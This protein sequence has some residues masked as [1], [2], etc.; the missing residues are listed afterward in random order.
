M[1]LKLILCIQAFQ[2][3]K[4]LLWRR[5][6]QSDDIHH[7]LVEGHAYT[8][9]IGAL[10]AQTHAPATNISLDTRILMALIAKMQILHQPQS[11]GSGHRS[12][13]QTPERFHSLKQ[14]PQSFRL[15]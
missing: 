8:K 14:P 7:R 5:I 6:R 13:G 11:P 4:C 9:Q 1:I 2:K 10:V 15:P 3:S 12:N